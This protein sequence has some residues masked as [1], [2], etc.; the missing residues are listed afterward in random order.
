MSVRVVL[1]TTA[2][3]AALRDM[4]TLTG[5]APSARIRRAD[6]A[7]AASVRW[8][9]AGRVFFGLTPAASTALVVALERTR[10][11]WEIGRNAKHVSWFVRRLR[12]GL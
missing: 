4:I 7:L 5:G 3:V 12:A 6:E 2:E 8:D 1:L 11:M 9:R 10:G